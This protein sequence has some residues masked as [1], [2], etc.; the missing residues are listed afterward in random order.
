M[1]QVTMSV[2]MD[3]DV[4]RLFDAY[5]AEMGM[6]ASVAVNIFAKAV[7]LHRGI[8]FEISVD[9]VELALDEADA[10]AAL[11]PRPLTHSEVFKKARARVN[12]V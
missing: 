10:E 9:P 7:I 11:S 12:G 2:R 3:E 8:P 5:C 4:K 6:N 1:S